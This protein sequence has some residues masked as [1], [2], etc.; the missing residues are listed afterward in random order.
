MHSN[1]CCWRSLNQKYPNK[2]C[3]LMTCGIMSSVYFIDEQPPLQIK[4]YLTDSG[5]N[6]DRQGHVLKFNFNMFIHLCRLLSSLSD[7]WWKHDRRKKWNAPSNCIKSLISLI[8]E[9][10][11]IMWVSAKLD[12]LCN[13]DVDIV[14]FGHLNVEMLYMLYEFKLSFVSGFYSARFLVRSQPQ[15]IH[16]KLRLNE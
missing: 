15:Y 9:T 4:I 12:K 6:V 3:S 11:G 13:K 1:Y 16:L 14:F 2:W 8:L 5:T 10:F 7:W